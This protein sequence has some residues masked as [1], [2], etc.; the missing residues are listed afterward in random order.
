MTPS[1]AGTP[2]FAAIDIG[3]NS[4]L[5]LVVEA[6]EG[7][8]VPVWDQAVITRLGRGVDEARRLDPDAV[9]RTLDCLGAYAKELERLQVQSLSVVGT[10]ALRDAEGSEAFLAQAERL[11]GTRPRII[12]GP[13]EAEL[14]FRGAVSGLHFLGP[15]TVFDVGGGSTEIIAGNVDV[16]TTSIKCKE[17]INIGAVRLHE[18]Y[19]RHDPIDAEE[20]VALRKETRRCLPDARPY[21]NS[22]VIGVAGTVTTLFAMTR[23]L[24]PYDGARVHGATLSRSEVE[25]WLLALE[26]KNLEERRLIPGLEPRRADVILAGAAIALEIFAWLELDSISVSDRGLRWGLV[27]KAAALASTDR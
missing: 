9:R 11:L 7:R 3:T 19:V 21:H 24:E 23:Q 25:H 16:D 15:A 5:L 17:S 4:V 26:Q 13:E 12:S 10:S 14:S 1:Q 8:L 27:E 6:R 18:R 20:L 2:R 22:T